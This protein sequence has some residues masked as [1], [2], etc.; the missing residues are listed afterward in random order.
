MTR[1]KLIAAGPPVA[2]NTAMLGSNTITGIRHVHVTGVAKTAGILSNWVVPNEIICGRLGRVLG[3][4]VPPGCVVTVE[5]VIPGSPPGCVV[6]DA[7]TLHYVSL[8]FNVSGQELAPVN[9]RAFVAHDPSLASR[10]VVFDAWVLNADRHERN[11]FFD[12]TT[13][14]IQVFDHGHA[15]FGPGPYVEPALEEQRTSLDLSKHV[16]PP[17]LTHLDGLKR[18][19]ER[20]Q[21]LPRFV[22]EDAVAA[23]V[24]TGITDIEGAF[25]VDFLMDRAQRLPELFKTADHA[26]FTGVTPELWKAF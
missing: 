5:G 15:L 23:A 13:G 2:G 11:V 12:L 20:V 21:A 1:Y 14:L 10:L 24:G 18:G 6:T 8:D 4:P 9:A 16:V 19:I 3:L 17:Y 22:V 7:G 25:C 26:R